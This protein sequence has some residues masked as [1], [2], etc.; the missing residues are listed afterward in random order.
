MTSTPETTYDLVII[1]AGPSGLAAALYAS[2]EGLKTVV[3]ERAVVGGMAAITDTI[4]N[5]PGFENGVGGL[6]LADHLFYH[7][8]RFGAEVKSGVEVLGLKRSADRISVKT[9]TGKLS[10]GAVLIATGSAYK[11]LGVPGEAEMIGRGVHFCATCDAPLY[12]GKTIIVV[13]GGNS[14]IQETLFIAKYASKV[15]MA[16]RGPKLTGTQILEEQLRALPNVDYVFNASVQAVTLASDRVT[17]VEI[18][19]KPGE[20]A[21]Q[22]SA[23]G[24][25]VFIGLLPNTQAFQ[26]SLD[27]DPQNFIITKPD[28]STNLP[29][30]YA[31]GDVRSGA[32][33][34]IA[35]A[36]GEGVSAT[37]QI[38]AYL[39]ALAHRRRHAAVLEPAD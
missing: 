20:P 32:T 18:T 21:R 9:S 38:R 16:V 13:G 27:L 2:R 15:T 23:D 1:G 6:E 4:D 24:V 36:I 7:A 22:L 10:A 14:A 25:F 35:S 5:Y 28:F 17:G 37:I 8:K 34:Q 12:K 19:G 11:Q 31:S 29:G 30:V 3:L 39:D 33:W 26:G